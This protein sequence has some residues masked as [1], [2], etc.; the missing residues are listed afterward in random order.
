MP[1]TPKAPPAKNDETKEEQGHQERDRS[2]YYDDAHGYTD[3]DP[4][5]EDEEFED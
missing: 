5:A 2:Y 4:E 1:E 3:F